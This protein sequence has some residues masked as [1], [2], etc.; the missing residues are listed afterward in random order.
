MKKVTINLDN[1]LYAKIE[2]MAKL[3]KQ[4][5]TSYVKNIILE[6]I[7]DDQDYKDAITAKEENNGE[8]YSESSV[9]K[10]LNMNKQSH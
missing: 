9:M 6:R 4:T 1:A 8:T 7:K 2:T 10:G 5:I 3:K